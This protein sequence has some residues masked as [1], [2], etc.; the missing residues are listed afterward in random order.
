MYF[1][2]SKIVE[3][4]I[5]SIKPFNGSTER[6]AEDDKN[7]LSPVLIDLVAG[8]CPNKRV[9]SGTVAA[10]AGLQVGKAYLMKVEERDADE[11]GRQFNFNSVM[12]VSAM[13]VFTA[14]EKFGNPKLIE[15]EGVT[16]SPELTKSGA[17]YPKGL[18]PEQKEEFDAL[19]AAKQDAWLKDP[20]NA[21]YV[22]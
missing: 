14:V 3:L 9:L 16:N 22:A 18:T 12:E 5:G 21:D 19:T 10:R 20:A 15:I 2:M 11:Y 6:P 17:P 8:K 7:G 4:F 1:V 13:D